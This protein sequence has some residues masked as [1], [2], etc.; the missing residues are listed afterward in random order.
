MTMKFARDSPGSLKRAVAGAMSSLR[1]GL[2][3]LLAVA[4]AALLVRSAGIVRPTKGDAW[5]APR[6]CMSSKTCSPLWLGKPP[7][8]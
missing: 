7:N 4:N 1:M 8:S 5:L 2:H 6:R 3:K